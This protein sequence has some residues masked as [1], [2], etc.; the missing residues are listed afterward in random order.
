[1]QRRSEKPKDLYL[2]FSPTCAS[3][4]V[5]ISAV[6][7]IL[8]FDLTEPVILELAT[9]ICNLF[10]KQSWAVCD[11]ISTQFRDEFFY[12]FRQLASKNPSEICGIL[13][14]DCADP[15]DPSE[16]G[17]RVEIPPKPQKIPRKQRIRKPK[18]WKDV[19]PLK[20][21]QLTDLHIDFDYAYPAE[22]ACGDPICCHS[23]TANPVK[24]AGYWGTVGACDVPYRTVDHMLGH[25]SSTQD[26]DVLLLTG[27]FINHA[28]WSYT[29]EEHLG[30]LRKLDDLVRRHFPQTPTY[31]ALGN[32]EG[33]PVNS[34][35]PHTVHERFWP[36]WLYKQFRTMGDPRGSYSTEVTRGLRIISL[37]TGFCEVTNFFL[38][39]NQSDPDSSMSWFVQELYQ[40]EQAGEAVFVMAHIPPGDSEC[41]EGWAINYYR[42]IQ[43]FSDTIRAQFFGHDHLD[44]FTVFYEDMH[45]VTSKPISVGY[46]APS[47]TTFENQNPAYRIYDVDPY[48]S[49]KI[50]DY[51]SYS[52]DL[53]ESTKPT[54]EPKW[55][56]LYSVKKEYGLR[57]LSPKSWN[58]LANRI[59]VDAD[60]K[61][62]FLRNAF[63]TSTPACDATCSRQLMCNLRMGHHNAS[64][65]CPPE[66]LHLL[67]N[68]APKPAYLKE[69]S[70]EQRTDGWKEGRRRLRIIPFLGIIYHCMEPRLGI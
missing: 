56:K 38:Y 2:Q 70:I 69:L 37:N 13:I 18:N 55:E 1:M 31:W 58:Q 50:L 19:R 28:D 68:R 53:N 29:V 42:V 7:L 23:Q 52:A 65:Y 63:R 41:L 49:F 3:C 30:V 34:F 22:A 16:A 51:T 43:R 5:A 54:E 59:F 66:N 60:V 62:K 45:N 6:S 33:V 47:V 67:D 61:H 25:I 17:W 14:S 32:H 64:L 9:I 40:A 11:G 26:V 12:V 27:D 15:T 10:A 35:A 39:I 8:K 46:A 48:S 4:T 44:F 36:T 57:D 24:P 21:L 20:V